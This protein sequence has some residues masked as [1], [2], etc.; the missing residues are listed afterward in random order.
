MAE[1]G[2]NPRV[3]ISY[4]HDSPVHK[5]WVANLANRLIKS[6]IYALIDQWDL[7]IGDSI[8]SY[9]ER[10]ISLAD[11]VLIICS[12][13]YVEKSGKKEGGV[14]YETAIITAETL[15]G[16]RKK[17]IPIIRNNPKKKLPDFLVDKL[18]LDFSNDN[19]F[20]ESFESLIRAIYSESP[21][22][23]PLGQNPELKP[24]KI[25]QPRGKRDK[26]FF[27]Y[28]HTDKKWLNEFQVMLAPLIRSGKI[29][30]W[31]DTKID[32]GD[33][34]KKEITKALQATKV[35]VLL[36]TPNFLA[37]QFIAEDELPP[38]LDAASSE[39]VTILWVAVS[40]SFYT[41]TEI[42]KYQATNNP[43]RPLD[44]LSKAQRNK[45]LVSICQEIL[46]AY[47]K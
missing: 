30:Q 20:E 47:E 31:D 12:E 6:G 2:Q 46:N 3:F 11:F 43:M 18:Y 27:S 26:V 13:N 25:K 10:G 7:R 38:L 22:P 4:S 15:Q 23:P 9:M 41:I 32:P 5:Q 45:E 21:K 44:M 24:T 17:V 33:E 14:G 28:S 40:S 1:S 39:G 8:V 16:Q 36:V 19:D 29:E 42:A 35:A 37:S 34:W